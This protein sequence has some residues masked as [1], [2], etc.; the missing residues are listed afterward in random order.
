MDGIGE[1]FGSSFDDVRRDPRPVVAALVYDAVAFG[2][3]VVLVLAVGSFPAGPSFLPFAAPG[4]LPTFTDVLD[5]PAV[6]MDSAGAL[7]GLSIAAA[8]AVAL[9]PVA[10][11]VEGGLVGVMKAAYI[12]RTDDALL[13]VFVASARRSFR[14]LLAYRI[15][16]HSALVASL[17]L[18][19]NFPGLHHEVLGPI[20]LRFALVYTPFVI[21][22]EGETA[23]GGMKR[24]VAAIADHL[25]TS[26][27]ML[28]FGLL[29]TG[30]ASA[31]A[32]AAATYTGGWAIAPLAVA[33]AVVATAVSTFVLKV[34]LGFRPEEQ[35]PARIV[36][37]VTTA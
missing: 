25:A 21:V 34:Y 24:S 19:R 5:V 28:L 27:V 12:D 22:I 6:A 32:K 26:L 9:A 23:W 36:P 13:P 14:P 10:A 16:L 30:G 8:L 20:V 7:R 37:H 3:L 4:A 17:V 18:G 31:L 11:W 35:A 33:Y 1:R 29:V 2:A 15:L